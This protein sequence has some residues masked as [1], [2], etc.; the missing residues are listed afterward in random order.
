MSECDRLK[1]ACGCGQLNPGSD[2]RQAHRCCHCGELRPIRLEQ[3]L[4]DER[5]TRDRQT[6]EPANAGA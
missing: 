6:E 1:W 4:A 2:W 5:L 3:R